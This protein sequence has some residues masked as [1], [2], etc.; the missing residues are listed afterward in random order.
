MVR[1]AEEVVGFQ[2]FC[3]FRTEVDL[4][5]SQ[6]SLN[7]YMNVEL[8]L[9][10]E[11]V[12]FASPNTIDVN[13]LKMVD[14]Q[15][16]QI[17]RP[18][19]GMMEFVPVT[20]SQT[21]YAVL[22]VVVHS[23][24]FDYK[25]RQSSLY[26]SHKEDFVKIITRE[27]KGMAMKPEN[28]AK[29]IEEILFPKGITVDK[30]SS[31][32]MGKIYDQLILPLINCNEILKKRTANIKSKFAFKLNEFFDNMEEYKVN[33]YESERVKWTTSAPFFSNLGELTQSL[34]EQVNSWAS[35]VFQQWND[36]LNTVIA[37]SGPFTEML[38]AEFNKA[39][40]HCFGQF[41]YRAESRVKD[42]PHTASRDT[43]AEHQNLVALLRNSL[44]KGIDNA[45]LKELSL[46]G[47][48]DEIPLLFED[49]FI[50]LN[51]SSKV[52]GEG[53]RGS[54]MVFVHGFQGS[55]FDGRTVRNVLALRLPEL[56][57]LCSA[58]NGGDTEGD[59]Q[60]MGQKLA[61]EVANHVREWYPQNALKK[62]SF[63]GHSLGGVI[64]RA[65]LPLLAEFKS[66]MH[67]FVTFSSPHL[68]YAY[69]DSSLVGAG[70]WLLKKWR[71][72]KCLEQLEMTDEKDHAESFIYRLSLAEG[73][74]WFKHVVLMSSFLDT[75]SPY[76]SSRVEV[77][78]KTPTNSLKEA[79]YI[80]MAAN[81]ISQIKANELYRVDV[82]FNIKKSD[83]NSLIGRE[84][85]LQFLESEA[86]MKLFAYRYA[87]LFTD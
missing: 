37:I 9:L 83:I 75:Y 32:Y 64:I 28:T 69:Q 25:F 50:R 34:I 14:R 73:L 11:P 57:T 2:E 70:M 8:F 68:G 18:E 36:Y 51:P 19:R 21:Y 22:N 39:R 74:G 48:P 65:A 66:K 67:L 24:L 1:F 26:F 56:Q 33:P 35:I 71:S 41:V 6:P 87:H 72:S 3:Q 60:A 52:S 85:H 53:T 58:A 78:R 62:L 86:L 10:E 13:G 76:E 42:F 40:A 31:A 79:V 38:L 27:N 4:L 20:F 82:A 77:F 43:A 63:F 80:Q 23:V 17:V 29:S 46:F 55:E 81:I 54:L 44:A 12:L 30:I 49:A 59:I 84:A 16:V 5:P 47:K 45:P 15:T 7:C 61:L